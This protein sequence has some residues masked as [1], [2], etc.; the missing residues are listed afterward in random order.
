MVLFGFEVKS[1]Y[2]FVAFDV[3]GK[4]ILRKESIAGSSLI[5]SKNET[6][7]GVFFLSLEPNDGNGRR[8]NLGKL[9]VQ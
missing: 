1:E 8:I 9:I 3:L 6:G 5:L 7:T 2:D 4:M